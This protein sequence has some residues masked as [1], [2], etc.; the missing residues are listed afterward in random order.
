MP[1]RIMLVTDIIG[2]ILFYGLPALWVVSVLYSF[3]ILRG[4]HTEETAKA[5]WAALILL[6]PVAGALAFLMV[7]A[8]KE[9][10]K[11]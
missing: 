5:I 4:I 11:K 6:I 1:G 8:G 3:S 9:G 2:L 7:W 10:K